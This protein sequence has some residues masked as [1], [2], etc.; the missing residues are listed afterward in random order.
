MQKE[1]I[2]EWDYRRGTKWDSSRQ[3]VQ[4]QHV[5]GMHHWQHMFTL[6]AFRGFMRAE[7]LLKGK[8][9]H[10]CE[11]NGNRNHFN[12][13]SRIQAT[14]RVVWTDPVRLLGLRQ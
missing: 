4:A 6:C 9:Q 5:R 13:L 12:L 3:K 8:H 1:V 2:L 14:I 7:D 11:R 10:L